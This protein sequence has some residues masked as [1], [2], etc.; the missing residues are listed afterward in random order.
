MVE[1]RDSSSA[2]MNLILFFNIQPAKIR[3]VPSVIVLW[4][5]FDEH[6]KEVKMYNSALITRAADP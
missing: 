3:N 2:T 6:S 5:L 4:V 1:Q